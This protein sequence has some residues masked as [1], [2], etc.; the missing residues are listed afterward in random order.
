MFSDDPETRKNILEEF[1]R[2]LIIMLGLVSLA[3][4]LGIIKFFLN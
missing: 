3:S 4:A 2:L 1:K